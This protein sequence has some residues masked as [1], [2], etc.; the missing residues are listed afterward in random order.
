MIKNVSAKK[1]TSFVFEKYCLY[2][3]HRKGRIHCMSLVAH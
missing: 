1:F 2:N 3:K